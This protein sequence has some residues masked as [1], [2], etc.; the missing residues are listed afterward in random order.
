MPDNA[1][2]FLLVMDIPQKDSLDNVVLKDT[3]DFRCS[4]KPYPNVVLFLA[5]H[6]QAKKYISH[7]ILR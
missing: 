7:G 6:N 3:A 4:A 5:L 2:I 1:R